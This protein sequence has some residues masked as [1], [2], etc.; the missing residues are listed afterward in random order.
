MRV[1]KREGQTVASCECVSK[2]TLG[3]GTSPLSK[4]PEVSGH[5]AAASENGY[6]PEVRAK[7]KEAQV[8]TIN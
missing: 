6:G 8:F 7:I 2:A 1:N 4:T 5:L 3:A